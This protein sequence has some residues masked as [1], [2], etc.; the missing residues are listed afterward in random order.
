MGRPAAEFEDASDR[1]KR[2]RAEEIRSSVSTSELTF[3]AQMSL[4]SSGN[5]DAASVLKDVTTTTPTRATKYREAIKIATTP[6][7]TKMSADEALV[8][9]VNLK[10]TKQQYIDLRKSLREEKLFAYPSYEKVLEAKKCYHPE[11]ITVTETSA[12]V[13]LQSLLYH[14][15]LEARNKYFK[16]YRES[17]SRKCAREKIMED[18]FQRMVITSD[19]FSSSLGKCSKAKKKLPS[20]SC[21]HVFVY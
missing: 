11:G 17:F 18:V 1:T 16:K 8:D 4:R 7:P 6:R 2:R 10:L 14:T 3:A 9:L 5:T 21:H 13:K 12:E 19:L 15:T 20:R